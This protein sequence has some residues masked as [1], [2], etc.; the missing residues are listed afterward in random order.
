MWNIYDHIDML[1]VRPLMHIG[2]KKISSL[3]DYLAWYRWCLSEKGIIENEN[4]KFHWF[5]DWIANRFHYKESTSGCENM[6]LEHSKDEEGA[7]NNFFILI[8]EYSRT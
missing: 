7:L 6:I 2:E 3:S 5:H 8:K 1:Q 4:P